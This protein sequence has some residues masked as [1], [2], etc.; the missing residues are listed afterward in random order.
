MV[1]LYAVA[2]ALATFFAVI[3]CVPAM[4]VMI[5]AAL[6]LLFA[7]ELRAGLRKLR[8]PTKR[9]LDVQKRLDQAA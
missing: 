2:S 5:G 6:V 8:R 1:A 7:W 4:L 9:A 3:G